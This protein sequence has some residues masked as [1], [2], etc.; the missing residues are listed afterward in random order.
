MM[1]GDLMNVLVLV[2]RIIHIFAAMFW[3]GGALIMEFFIGPSVAATGEGGQQVARHLTNKI[4]IHI[5]MMIAAISTVL[6]G[7]LLYWLDSDGF[8]SAWMRSATG[9]GFAIGGM[10]GFVAFIFGAIFGNSN[11]QL[12]Q[13]SAQINGKPTEEQRTRMQLLQKRIQRVS[14]IH[15]TSTILAMLFMATA[16]YLGLLLK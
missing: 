8:S 2:L 9:I 7:A 5:F 3:G 6:A 10:F 15:V 11:A 13:I 1:E 4:R 14:P 16:R 12:G